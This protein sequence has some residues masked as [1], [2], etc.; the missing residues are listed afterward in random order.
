MSHSVNL[1]LIDSIVEALILIKGVQ[2]KLKFSLLLIS[3]KLKKKLFRFTTIK[4]Y[5]NNI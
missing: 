3:V 4:I 5:V 2:R 1:T